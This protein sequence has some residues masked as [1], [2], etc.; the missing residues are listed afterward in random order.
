MDSDGDGVLDVTDQCRLIKGI[1]P[2]GCPAN[3]AS[4]QIKMLLQGAMFNTS[5]GLMR[6]DLRA[7]G[8]IPVV[9]PYTAFASARFTHKG[10]GGGETLGSTVTNISGVNAIVDWVFVELRDANNPSN[11]IKTKAALLQRDGDVVE[12][13]DGISPVKFTDVA[14]LSFY[15]AVKHR[16]HLGAMTSAPIAVTTSGTTVDFTTMTSAQTWNNDTNY[17]GYEQVNNVV[18]SGKKALW[19]GNTDANNKVKYVG[20]AN[21]QLIIFSQVLEYAG[22]VG[23]LYNYDFATPVYTQ[24]DVNM[25]GKVKYRGSDNDSNYIFGNIVSFYLLNTSK[26]YNYDLL[27]EQIP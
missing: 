15:V 6:D 14:G 3:T 27:L 20:P 4:I 17:D 8:I 26:L 24:G 21:D 25:D 16:N 7:K 18:G 13:T 19:A 1:A 2:T 5:D 22:N 10:G 23:Q 11:V 12:S 9:E